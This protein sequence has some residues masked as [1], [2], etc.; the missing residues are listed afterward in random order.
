[1][2]GSETIEWMRGWVQQLY[3]PVVLVASSPEAEAMCQSKNGL[4]VVDL[5]R[6]FSRVQNLS[7]EGRHPLR[8]RSCD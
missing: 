5:L 7:G 4:T 1:M 6:P 8:L 3:R 2:V